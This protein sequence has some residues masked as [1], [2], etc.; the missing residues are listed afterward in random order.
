MKEN[1]NN[2]YRIDVDK[3]WNAL[4]SRLE[5]EQL[6]TKKVEFP[7]E[8][9]RRIYLQRVA[10]VAAICIGVAFSVFYFSQGKDDSLVS[11]Q[12]TENSGTLVTT[13]ED[14]STVYLEANASISYPSTFAPDQR[15]VELKGNALFSVAKN[16]NRPFIVEVNGITIEVVGTIFAVE[17][18]SGNSFELSVK[19]GKVNVLSKNDKIAIP[20]EAGEIVQLHTGKLSKSKITNDRVF[21]QFTYKMCF[22][23]EKLDDIV[24]AINTMYGSPTIVTEKSTSNRTLTVT[25]ENNS[26]ETMTELICYALNLEHVNKQDTIVIR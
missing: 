15:K 2:N 21:S 8:R 20:V 18:D 24:R 14:G 6:L 3:A 22:K 1:K 26:V 12:N 17:S 10:A 7:F 9:K 5:E 16:K 11:L 25:F 4:Y 19:E 23:D 13:L